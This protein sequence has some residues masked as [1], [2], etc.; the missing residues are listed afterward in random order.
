MK[1]TGLKIAKMK[2]KFKKTKKLYYK[3][4]EKKYETS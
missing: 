3:R 4:H 1:I 2:V